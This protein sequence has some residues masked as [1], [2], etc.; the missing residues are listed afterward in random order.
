MVVFS[1]GDK[2]LQV[3][4]PLIEAIPEARLNLV[5]YHLR[6]HNISEAYELLKDIEPSTPPEYILKGVVHT[7]IGQAQNNAQHLKIAQQC[8]QLVGTSAHECDTIPGRQCMASCFFLMKQFDDVNI[9]LNSIKAYMYNDDDF[10]YDHGIALAA[11]RNYKAAEEALLMVHNDKYKSEYIYISWLARCYI[12]NGN[13]RSAWELYLKMS[14]SSE[15]FN[16]LQLIA[17]DCY[18]VSELLL[19][20]FS[21]LF[22]NRSSYVFFFFFSSCELRW[23]ISCTLPRPS[24]SWSD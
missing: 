24:M 15:S 2:A 14:N 21:E 12:M 16:L 22:C 3:L 23:A 6:N 13:P 18:R 10:N 11:T 4:P 8:F 17:N 7:N 20:I 1:N 9:Y 19:F 5:I